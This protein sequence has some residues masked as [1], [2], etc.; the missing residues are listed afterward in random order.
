MLERVVEDDNVAA[1][2]ASLL[3]ADNPILLDNDLDIGIERAVHEDFIVTVASQHDGGVRSR[4]SQAPRDVRCERRLASAAHR[5]IADAER[6]NR[7][8]MRR[9]HA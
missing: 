4:C 1:T 2:S 6:R 7:R 3:A 5:E 8:R 9:Q